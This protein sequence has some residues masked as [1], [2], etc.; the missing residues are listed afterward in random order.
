M[1]DRGPGPHRR[2]GAVRVSQRRGRGAVPI[3][4][5]NQ[6]DYKIFDAQLRL[7]PFAYMLQG[8]ATNPSLILI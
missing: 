3:K 2:G 8:P 1:I 4:A 7:D 5:Y 6:D